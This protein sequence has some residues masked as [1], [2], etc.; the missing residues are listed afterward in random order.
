LP[1]GSMPSLLFKYHAVRRDEE[2]TEEQ[3]EQE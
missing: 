1:F 2:P 3:E